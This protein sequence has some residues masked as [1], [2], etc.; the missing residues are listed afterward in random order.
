MHPGKTNSALLLK[1]VGVFNIVERRR[2]CRPGT[3]LA[4]HQSAISSFFW[5]GVVIFLPLAHTDRELREHRLRTNLFHCSSLYNSALVLGKSHR[6][7]GLHRGG[8]FSNKGS[9]NIMNSLCYAR[10]SFAPLSFSP[11]CKLHIKVLT[12]SEHRSHFKQ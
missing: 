3:S 4:F 5:G 11:L 6:K 1:R 8:C 9:G 10:R 2:T 12:D 7:L